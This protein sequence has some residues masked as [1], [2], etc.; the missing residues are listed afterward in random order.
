MEDLTNITHLKLLSPFFGDRMLYISSSAQ[1]DKLFSTATTLQEMEWELYSNRASLFDSIVKSSQLMRIVIH[2]TDELNY[3]KFEAYHQLIV[4]KFGRF[5]EKLS[6]SHRKL[7]LL[8]REQIK[9]NE[10]R[11]FSSLVITSMF[12]RFV[13]R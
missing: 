10:E 5:Y 1:G 13:R 3:T 8:K 4:K 12:N 11:L 7:V 2:K 9:E 6:K